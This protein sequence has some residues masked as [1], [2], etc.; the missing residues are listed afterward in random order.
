MYC[1]FFNHLWAALF[2]LPWCPFVQSVLNSPSELALPTPH[3]GL[4]KHCVFFPPLWLEQTSGS[5]SYLACHAGRLGTLLHLPSLWVEEPLS[6][7]KSAVC[8][9]VQQEGNA[10]TLCCTVSA[11][12]SVTARLRIKNTHHCHPQFHWTVYCIGYFYLWCTLSNLNFSSGCRTKTGNQYLNKL[13]WYT[14]ND[15]LKKCNNHMWSSCLCFFTYVSYVQKN[16]NFFYCPAYGLVLSIGTDYGDRD[17]YSLNK[18]G[19]K[20]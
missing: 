15:S 5:G 9:S 1:P 18:L 19:Q 11:S 13:A 17:I 20:K 12:C 2:S 10:D 14:V 4:C 6:L 8:T 7:D 3:P 16:N